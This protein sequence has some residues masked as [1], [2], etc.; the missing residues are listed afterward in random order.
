MLNKYPAWK[1][2]LVLLVVVLGFL[3]SSPNLFPDD[4]A[5]Q[6]SHESL[7]VTEADMATVT[8]ALEA[9]QIEFFGDVVENES[10]LVHSRIVV[11]GPGE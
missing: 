11:S 4:P 7:P 2:I 3:Y 1:N 10:G 5:L 9:A 6:I 8:T